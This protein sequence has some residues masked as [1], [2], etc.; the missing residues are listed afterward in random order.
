MSA[1][2]QHTARRKKEGKQEKVLVDK[3]LAKAREKGL[4]SE[5][6]VNKAREKGFVDKA[7]EAVSK[8]RNK[9]VGR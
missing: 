5:S 2:E 7:G 3:A 9:L 1:E 8:I 6:M 4:V